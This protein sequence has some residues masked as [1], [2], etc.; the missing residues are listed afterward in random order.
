M[1]NRLQLAPARA[2]NVIWV[3]GDQMRA[4][5]MS[6]RGDPN[7]HTP[8]LDRLAREGMRFDAAVAGA[9][10][11]CP[12]RAALLT[13][14]YP[15]QCG[16]IQTP[17][18]LNPALPTLT[19]PFRAAGYHTAYVGKWHLGGSNDREHY[20]PPEERGGFDYWVGYENNNNAYE[21]YVYG[22]GDETPR[23][24]PGYETDALTDILVAHL[25][26]HS[27][28]R[29]PGGA[30]Q[31]FFAVLSVQ[32]PHDPYLPP[33]S[34]APYL[35][36]HR[37][38][39]SIVFRPNVPHVRRL[40]E[41]AALDLDGYYGMIENLD[42]NVGRLR[43]ALRRLDLDR[44]T[45][46]VFFSDHGDMVG[47]HGQWYKSSPWEEAI[48]IPF[49]VARG[50]AGEY[51]RTGMC[52]APLNHVDIAPTTLGLCGI[53]IPDSLTGHDYSNRCLKPRDRGGPAPNPAE[54]P[55]SAYLQQI[56]RKMYPRTVNKSW[57]GVA[58]RD[59]WKYI[60]MPGQDWLLHDTLQDPYEMANWAHDLA[61]REQRIRCLRRLRRWIEETGDDFPLPPED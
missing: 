23:R 10:W 30:Y 25:E 54:E 2:P 19:K 26:A 59:G 56:P 12:F 39:A 35:S 8:N 7:V 3:F 60:A 6:H 48:R 61:F 11:C 57:R 38:P 36:G 9:P 41:R 27:R 50:S 49:I 43:E 21:T 4:Q 53:P 51:C 20:I 5:A 1:E 22:G 47:S 55:D 37:S 42:W 24:L 17:Q 18:R 45:W 31:P 28:R 14:L 33:A 34:P 16:V 13:G 15:H 46:I 29:D 52:D 44:E 58:M 40:R 32:P